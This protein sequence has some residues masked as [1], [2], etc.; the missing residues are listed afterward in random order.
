MF[1]YSKRI[2]TKAVFTQAE[3]I[4][5]WKYSHWIP[6]HLFSQVFN[7]RNTFETRL[8]EDILWNSSFW[9]PCWQ[10]LEYVLPWFIG[11]WWRRQGFLALFR[12][13]VQEKENS[14]FKLG[15]YCLKS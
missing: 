5:E 15:V 13:L 8:F 11:N 10:G 2:K 12:Q 3:M 4:N 9:L 14:E 1:V 6:M 7:L